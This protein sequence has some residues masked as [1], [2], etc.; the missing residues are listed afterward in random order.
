MS[1]KESAPKDHTGLSHPLAVHDDGIHFFG[2]PHRTES[3]LQK[4]HGESAPVRRGASLQENLDFT[5]HRSNIHERRRTATF[6]GTPVVLDLGPPE[7][8]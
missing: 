5:F 7:M 3:S 6:D 2:D 4:P 8:W 1:L